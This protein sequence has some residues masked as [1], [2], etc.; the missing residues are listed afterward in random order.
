MIVKL[1]QRHWPIRSFNGSLGQSLHWSRSW[2]LIG[3]LVITLFLAQQLNIW[4]DEAYSLDTT[5]RTLGYALERSLNYEIQP[6][7]YFILLTLWRSL[8]DSIFWARLFS[9]L[10]ITMALHLSAGLATRYLKHTPPVWL[11]AALAFHP[12]SIWAAVELRAYAFCILISVLLLLLFFDAYLAETESQ[13]ARWGYAIVVLAALYS[14]YFLACLI[15]GQ[16]VVL[17]LKRGAGQRFYWVSMIAVGLG[18]LPLISSLLLHVEGGGIYVDTNASALT[19]LRAAVGR[20][21]VFMLPT[22]TDWEAAPAMRLLRYGLFVLLLL[23]LVAQRR[24]ITAQNLT[25]WGMSSFT[26]LAFG[27]VLT[28]TH[29]VE[30]TYR[31][32]Y[33][34]LVVMLLSLFSV[35]SLLTSRSRQRILVCLT[36]LLLLLYGSSLIFTY[37][38]LA[39]DG[40]WQRVATYITDSERPNQPILGFSAE[41][42]LPLAY[43]YQ[44]R[45]LLLPLPH[46]VNPD[47]YLQDEFILKQESEV[48][49]ALAQAGDPSEVWLVTGPQFILGN[50]NQEACVLFGANFNCQILEQFVQKH[51]SV[52]LSKD[53]YGSR[54]RFLRQKQPIAPS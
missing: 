34:L 11:V 7:L 24:R 39:K 10:C 28:A 31:Y 46:P 1:W 15:A 37:R 12:F 29:T 30:L 8:N 20:A 53:F 52:E 47:R 6:P 22:A 42:M 36:L 49:A 21:L 41:V 43:Y 4:I 40:D 48:S 3:H 33:P 54:V 16:A 38:A 9:T 17:L 5:S 18:F 45:N 51:Y 44:G 32:G 35:L 25:V 27:L 23:I 26:V 13:S 19:G 2:P 14:H 50:P